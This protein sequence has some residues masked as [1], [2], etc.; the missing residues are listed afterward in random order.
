LDTYNNEFVVGIARRLRKSLWD[1]KIIEN[2]L[3][4]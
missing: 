1:Q 3:F 2:L 4:I